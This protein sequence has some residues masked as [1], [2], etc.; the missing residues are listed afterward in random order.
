MSETPF[1]IRVELQSSRK[2]FMFLTYLYVKTVVRNVGKLFRIIF[3]LPCNRG[4][5]DKRCRNNDGKTDI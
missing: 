4:E 2:I 3:V 5:Q 1:M